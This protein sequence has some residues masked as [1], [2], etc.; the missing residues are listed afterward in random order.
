[1]HNHQ[2]TFEDQKQITEL[3]ILDYPEEEAAR[4]YFACGKDTDKAAAKL[5][6]D[7]T[8]N[9]RS[10]TSFGDLMYAGSYIGN[11]NFG[12]SKKMHVI[13]TKFET[14]ILEKT[15]KGITTKDPTKVAKLIKEDTAR[16]AAA[17]DFLIQEKKRPIEDDKQDIKA[18]FQQ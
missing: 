8:F 9:K 10:L 1:M 11:E 12:F 13:A 18:C 4:A 14:R 5:L 7:R 17:K 2:I 6:N 16:E 15:L 3:V